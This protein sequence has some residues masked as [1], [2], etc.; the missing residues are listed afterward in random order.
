MHFYTHPQG[1]EGSYSLLSFRDLTE[2]QWGSNTGFGK[3]PEVR[4]TPV[5]P[6][7]LNFHVLK[8]A[9]TIPIQ[10]MQC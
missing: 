3:E 4:L 9:C 1:E 7:F 6:L 5:N 8:E 2:E 10:F